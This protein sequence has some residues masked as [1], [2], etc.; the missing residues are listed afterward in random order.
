[1]SLEAVRDA[2]HVAR[3]RP[4]HFT[5]IEAVTAIES[6]SY[7]LPW[8][9]GIFSGQLA[10]ETGLAL[11]CEVDGR[12]AGYLIADMF[13]DVWHL[14]NLCVDGSYRR[15]HIASQLIEGY[16]A[17]TE[18]KGHRGHTLEVRV[19]NTGAI[20]LYRSFGFVATGVRPGY[21]SD[22]REDAVIMWKDWE[23]ESA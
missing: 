8:A 9:M 21:Y 10:R 12:V 23:G 18:R 14:M 7:S 20:E 4:M 2:S 17:I 15:Q 1:M 13:V 11:V 22:D 3:V 6:R 16:F 19:S 5:D